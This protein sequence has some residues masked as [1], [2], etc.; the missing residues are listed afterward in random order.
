MRLPRN[1][2]TLVTPRMRVVAYFQ[3][4]EEPI[5]DSL[6]VDTEDACIEEVS[7]VQISE[8]LVCKSHVNQITH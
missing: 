3:V 7:C 6:E 4:D 5:V 8:L 2:Y 1:L